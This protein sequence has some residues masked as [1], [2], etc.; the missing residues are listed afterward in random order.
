MGLHPL[1]PNCQPCPGVC[2]KVAPG[3]S[4]C[5]SCRTMQ[6]VM[7]RDS[8]IKNYF[9]KSLLLSELR[10]EN[11]F[12]QSKDENCFI[13]VRKCTTPFV[14]QM[15]TSSCSKNG[16]GSRLTAKNGG[17]FHTGRITASRM[18]AVCRT[19]VEKPARSLIKAICYPDTGR[20]RTNATQ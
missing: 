15:T 19:R 16:R 3:L 17:R 1:M 7:S 9:D 18:K 6:R 12:H 4:F 2:V 13:S 8:L 14:S 10:D 5:P 20:F 11:A